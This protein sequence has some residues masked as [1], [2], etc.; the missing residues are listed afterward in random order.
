MKIVLKEDVHKLGKRGETLNVADGYA[1][2]YLLPKGL[3]LVANS[4]N[5]R[6][7]ELEKK[8]IV[9][10]EIKER[11]EAEVL[12]ARLENISLT[13]VKKVG[14]NDILYGSVT[15]AEI[16]DLLKNEGIEIDKKKIELDE[17]IKTTGIFT[18]PIKIYKDISA[19]IKLWIVKE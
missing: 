6:L 2:N 15:T 19:E 13:V 11:A 5:L 10:K 8:K 12:A 14:E 7:L 16:S 3:A 1:R 9:A 17:A 18:I 4:H